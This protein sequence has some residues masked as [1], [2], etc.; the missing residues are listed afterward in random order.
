MGGA[1][2]RRPAVGEEQEPE[3]LVVRVP[4]ARGERV[5]DVGP[6][7][8][9]RATLLVEV[10]QRADVE[11]AS[12][13]RAGELDER[14][15]GRPVKLVLGAAAGIAEQ[16][17]ELHIDRRAGLGESEEARECSDGDGVRRASI[18]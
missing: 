3:A 8:G 14:A 6:I 13:G 15:E 4:A 1:R 5:E 16:G 12:L 11:V 10:E 9:R 17:P 7:A 2:F 18:A